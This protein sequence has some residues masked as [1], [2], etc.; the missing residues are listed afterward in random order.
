VHYTAEFFCANMTVEMD[1][2]DKLKVLFEDALKMGITFE[3]PDVNRGHYRFEPI[4]DKVIRYGLGAVKGTGQQAIEA[5]VKAR[6]E[7]GLFT[8]LYDFCVRVDR[9]RLN[10]RTI[11]ALIKAG[12]F[13]SL[14]LNRASLIASIDRAFDFANATAANA[15]QGGLF[16]MMG[17]DA[18]GAST[19][20]PELVDVLPWGVKERLTNEKTA[21]G[22]YLSGHLF[23]E[24]A[25]EVRRFAKRPLGD[26]IDTRE[27]QLLAGIVSDFRVINGQRGKLGLFKFDDK[28]AVIDARVDEALM[29]AHKHLFKDDELII[30]MGKVM[31]DRF[32]GGLQLTVNQVWDLA[33]ARCRFGKYLRVAVNGR[34]PD[35]QRLVTD[36]PPQRE[37]TEQ[38][39]LLRGLPVRLSLRRDGPG[40][41]ATAELQLG[42]DAK[43]FPSDA[44]LAGWMAQAD[45]GKALIVYE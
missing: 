44:A 9:T 43:F 35:I 6:E 24:V 25:L 19:Q 15:N 29:N 18:H 4:S 40:V 32:S 3:P 28:S 42:E 20:E 7:G 16:D 39:E 8:S 38:G 45:Q 31:P 36:F 30:V 12:A 33:T 21:I 34:A 2:T 41:G 37:M 1:D 27:P 14:H 11:E 13:D 5:I 10:K 17:E 22:F 26:L 23:D